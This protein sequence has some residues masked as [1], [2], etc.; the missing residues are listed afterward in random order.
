MASVGVLSPDTAPSDVQ[1]APIEQQESKM[2]VDSDRRGSDGDTVAEAMQLQAQ[3]ENLARQADASNSM[4]GLEK[5]NTAMPLGL[6]ALHKELSAFQS[7]TFKNMWR[8][9]SH[10]IAK[11]K[12]LLL[13]AFAMLLIST[14]YT[15]WAPQ[16]VAVAIRIVF[17]SGHGTIPLADFCGWLFLYVATLA[18]LWSAA[19]S[20]L[21]VLYTRFVQRMRYHFAK[22]GERLYSRD[23]QVADSLFLERVESDVPQTATFWFRT[24]P[25][26]VIAVSSILMGLGMI[27]YHSWQVG[28]TA[29]GLFG[30]FMLLSLMV[31][32]VAV[33]DASVSAEE[34]RRE[35][36]LWAKLHDHTT[37]PQERK[38]CL[39]QI[40]R[41]RAMRASHGSHGLVH[42]LVGVLYRVLAF[43]TPVI[44]FLVAGRNVVDNDM[45]DYEVVVIS[46]YFTYVVLCAFMVNSVMMK[47]A[48]HIAAGV[49]LMGFVHETHAGLA[50]SQRSRMQDALGGPS[51]ERNH[52]ELRMATPWMI[53]VLTLL[54][55][56]FT[57]AVTALL[58]N[59][60][61]AS[62]CPEVEYTC[63]VRI[64]NLDYDGQAVGTAK[65]QFDMA[66]GCS[67]EQ[68]SEELIQNCVQ[69]LHPQI[70]ANMGVQSSLVS[71]SFE[72]WSGVNRGYNQRLSIP[73]RDEADAF[74]NSNT[75]PVRAAA[76]QPEGSV[77]LFNEFVPI[78]DDPCIYQPCGP[79]YP[80]PRGDCIPSNESPYYMCICYPP[81]FGFNCGQLG[82]PGDF[83]ENT[84]VS[85]EEINSYKQCLNESLEFDPEV[86]ELCQNLTE[87]VNATTLHIKN[88]VEAFRF[89]Y[90]HDEVMRQK[91]ALKYQRWYESQLRAWEQEQARLAVE[92]E[93]E[94]RCWARRESDCSKFP[95]FYD[96]C[97]NGKQALQDL[98]CRIIDWLLPREE[99]CERL[100]PLNWD[101]EIREKT[102]TSCPTA[103]CTKPARQNIMIAGYHPKL[104]DNGLLLR[105][106][107][108]NVGGNAS[109]VIDEFWGTTYENIVEQLLEPR[110]V[111]YMCADPFFKHLEV[112]F[113]QPM[114]VTAFAV[115]G[116]G[117][118]DLLRPPSF[119][120]VEGSNDGPLVANRTW[121]TVGQANADKWLVH[122][123]Q[124]GY[125]FDAEN[126]VL[127]DRPGNYRYYR[128]NV[129]CPT[130]ANGLLIENLAL[131]IE[132]DDPMVKD[133]FDDSV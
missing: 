106:N 39:L 97:M 86:E 31:D 8:G 60:A 50:S 82:N 120:F 101:C 77:Q 18:L 133:A 74:V 96:A 118:A 17:M 108:T 11:D 51:E 34:K 99:L 123:S 117:D 1:L 21:Y 85:I 65:Q 4:L 114:Y 26:V 83:I 102:C 6:R 113:P 41:I 95:V 81:W 2:D 91:K 109:N 75:D 111:A 19:A 128:V 14:V 80:S 9:S 90:T 124:L 37:S 3:H 119:W 87:A 131:Y 38:E 103:I 54:F 29:L 57:I 36:A 15:F 46:T 53:V 78:Q 47:A 35:D 22:L 116:W 52:S 105:G 112:E 40:N 70:P 49:K 71:V 62:Q 73:T 88:T 121:T 12:L 48:G 55:I 104:N 92:Q 56:G 64:D 126:I 68:S 69:M 32:E 13:A 89:S 63:S 122:D 59:N 27:F 58:M 66:S 79:L 100:C 98:F 44:L 107:I 132:G 24:L 84:T 72:S 23:S 20:L 115:N 67:F 76:V 125:P 94:D 33:R 130:Q 30:V 110:Y 45:N 61:S 42:I 5:Y 28:L 7:G 93:Q 127:A 10:Y 43:C 129:P 16:W 25:T